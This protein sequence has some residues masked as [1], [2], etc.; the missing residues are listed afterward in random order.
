VRTIS[1]AKK[2]F[3]DALQS[4]ALW[5]LVVAFVVVLLITTYAYVEFPE[6]F[7][8]NATAT[9]GGLL[10]YT[11]G[12][13]APFI[14]L[15]AIVVCFKSIAGE[16]ELGSIK[17]LLSLPLTRRD[18]FSGKVIGRG[19]VLGVGLGIGLLVGLAFGAIMLGSVA[20]VPL[21]L[22]LLVTLVFAA[23]YASVMVSLSALTGSTARATTL[24]IG[25][26]V[27]FEAVWD[28]VPLAI[29][30]VIE[31]FTIPSQLPE[32]VFLVQQLSPSTAYTNAI[33]AL[34]PEIAADLGEGLDGAAE[35]MAFY[36]TPEVGFVFLLF[37]LVIPPAIAY[38]RFDKSDL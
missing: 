31:G 19:A 3:R 14:P 8:S 38:N 37:W 26:F 20:V 15:A 1:V 18:A 25:Y 24:A 34:L 17:I 33:I 29:V 9:F 4:R 13:V 12:I 23:L 36:V 30:Y 27:V 21:V 5:G 35:S 22:F 7:S 6:L 32:W 28:V 11:S 10:F 2:D 16:R